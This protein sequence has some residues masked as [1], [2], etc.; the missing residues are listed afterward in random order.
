VA[1]RFLITGLCLFVAGNAY[2]YEQAYVYS[3]C[4]ENRMRLMFTN[5]S[6]DIPQDQ[7]AMPEGLQ[8]LKDFG[9]GDGVICNSDKAKFSVVPTKYFPHS[10]GN[11][12]AQDGAE[13]RI[14]NDA[15]NANLAVTIDKS[16]GWSQINSV[17]LDR[18]IF[19]SADEIRICSKPSRYDRKPTETDMTGFD[20]IVF[21]QTTDQA[22]D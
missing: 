22:S 13:I 14:S 6:E 8:T 7:D 16:H 18:Q 2:A 11:F 9:A 21:N 19:I 20:C 12:G 15:D 4:T 3:E 10:A 1:F 5:I 17:R